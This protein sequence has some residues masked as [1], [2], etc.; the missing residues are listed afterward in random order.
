M[1]QAQHLIL[2]RYG[3]AV[4]RYLLG[5][6]RDVA[7]AE[8]LYQEFALRFLR[9]DFRRADPQRGRFRDFVKTALFRLVVRY[10]RKQ[11][12]RPQTLLFDPP[13]RCPGISRDE[14]FLGSWRDELLARAWQALQRYQAQTG[15]PFYRVLRLRAEQPQLRSE[16]L[17]RILGDELGKPLT[18]VCVRQMVHRAREKFADFLLS[19]VRHS[20]ADPSQGQLEQELAELRLLEYCKPVLQRRNPKT[21]CP[22]PEPRRSEANAE[23]A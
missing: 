7:A 5:A 20:L 8:E 23:P 15:Q 17:A 14:Q 11:Q 18:A 22:S 3:G 19:E 2:E 1:N 12:C 4:Y 9:G 13:Q 21:H 6:L 10:Y 16:E